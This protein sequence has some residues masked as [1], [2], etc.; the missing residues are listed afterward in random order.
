MLG[1][2]AYHLSAKFAAADSVD[3]VTMQL[4]YD[5]QLATTNEDIWAWRFSMNEQNF[6]AVDFGVSERWS[7]LLASVALAS[8]GATRRR[9]PA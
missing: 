2:L 8:L 1:G 5:G 7:A 4:F 6:V 9:R 3:G